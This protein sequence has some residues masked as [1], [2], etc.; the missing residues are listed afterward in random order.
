MRCAAL[1]RVS[2][3]V[4]QIQEV[5]VDKGYEIVLLTGEWA[6]AC[7]LLWRPFQG[8][9]STLPGASILPEALQ[10]HPG[11]LSFMSKCDFLVGEELVE[12][13]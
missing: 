4:A 9:G 8:G 12:L 5:T 3:S 6:A 11:N 2:P 1:A 13:N 10:E 7:G